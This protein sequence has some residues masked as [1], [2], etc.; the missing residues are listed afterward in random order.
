MK[1]RVQRV[2]GALRGL[3]AAKALSAHDSWDAERLRRHQRERLLATVRH[4]AATSPYYRER[5]AGIELS[6][7][8]DP[9]ALPTLDKAA[10]LE[11]FDELV[12]DPRLT[13]AGVEAHLADLE[14]SDDD[15]L[16][17]G[18]YRVMASGGST[19]RRGVFVYGRDD[20]IEI[21]GGFIRW[22]SDFLGQ[23][24]RFPH[25]R[26]IAAISADSPLHMTGRMGLSTDIGLHRT[27]RLDAR[28]PLG[29][30]VEVLDAYQPET[31]VG[32][33]SSVAQLAGEQ[34]AGRLRIAPDVVAT[35]SEVR[36]AEMEE[37]ILA[38]WG[39]APFNAYAS[40]ETG[41]LAADCD[42]HF[43]MHLF[44]DLVYLEVLDRAGRP[45]RPGEPGSRVLV[46]NL[47]NRAQP[48]IRFELGDL[49]T[50]SD[51]ACLCGRPHPL[52]ERVD[53]RS[54]D[55]LDLPAAAGGTVSV[56]PLAIR[57]PL[58]KV[59]DLAEY[60]VLCE[61][62][63]LRVQAVLVG[64]AGDPG[65]VTEEIAS[66]LNASLA[67]RGVGALPIVVE[68]VR[69]IPRHPRTGKRRLI[70]TSDANTELSLA[71]DRGWD[72]VPTTPQP[73]FSVES[74]PPRPRG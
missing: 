46:T 72:D 34:L 32:Y 31:L 37:R 65:P 15:A 8:L 50:L 42:R 5:L 28:E 67:E 47:V 19:G 53:G 3:R 45:V 61:P 68:H 49:I 55:V 29:K 73:L 51:R 4:A 13:L 52:L 16:L 63:S 23:T 30:Q 57:S 22:T 14:H 58:A 35:T 74:P 41:F 38:A 64:G 2:A 36:T 71:R 69:E 1:E 7:D 62:E 10:M 44:S 48:L 56:H 24:P 18:E 11:H 25:R 12:T 21:L 43:G 27:V 60:R 66:R 6:D 59:A 39:R 26:R 20:W 40:T 17:L 33:S 9:A 54:D 70:E